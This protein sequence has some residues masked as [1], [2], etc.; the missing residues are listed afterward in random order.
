MRIEKKLKVF[1]L[2]VSRIPTVVRWLTDPTFFYNGEGFYLNP[3]GPILRNPKPNVRTSFVGF[4]FNGPKKR[5]RFNDQQLPH[6]AA[7]RL[8]ALLSSPRA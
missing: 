3:N 4:I 6:T 5:S 7:A 2:P 8:L 1:P